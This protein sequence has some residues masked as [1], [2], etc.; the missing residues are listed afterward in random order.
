MN[1]IPIIIDVDTGTDDAIALICALQMPKLL[2]IKAITTV[3]GNV[4][5]EKT[6]KNTID[7]TS[8]LDHDVKVAI[9]ASKPLKKNHERAIIH[10]NSGLG[11]VVLP[12]SNKTFYLKSSADTI[13]EEALRCNGE[14]QLLAIGPLTNV[15]L[16]IQ[17]YPK[18][19]SLIKNITIMGGCL[20]GGNMT[21]ASEFN[22]YNDPEAAKIVFNSGIPVTMVGLDVTLKPTLPEW[23]Y[24][25]INNLHTK[26][27]NISI[28]IFDFMN[29][30]EMEYSG[31]Y[32][33]LHD[34]IALCA[35]TTNDI[36]T[37]EQYY[38]DVE[39]EGTITRGMTVADFNNVYPKK[40]SNVNAAVNININSF[41]NWLISIYKG[42]FYE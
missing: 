6:S 24:N 11:D 4:E 28:S 19:T 9:G 17:Q 2:D 40:K 23:V 8:L 13:Y 27:S 14:L 7:L 3:M 26:Y 16:A 34:V 39:C 18:L 1:N 10:G 20:I 33:N 30:M 25:E 37:Y 36:I 42:D 5:I 31:G 38:I 15:A 22:I 29:K 35:L 21:Q 12:D 32:A 41:W